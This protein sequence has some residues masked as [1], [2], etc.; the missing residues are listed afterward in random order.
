MDYDT[1]I[2]L[3]NNPHYKLSREQEIELAKFEKPPMVQ[4]GQ[5]ALH[6][7]NGYKHQVKVKKVKNEVKKA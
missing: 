2:M 3:K 1:L 5:P 4:F 6:N 7:Q